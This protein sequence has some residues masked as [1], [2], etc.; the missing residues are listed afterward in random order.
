M[1]LVTAWHLPR[2]RSMLS[3]FRHVRRLD[4]ATRTAEGCEWV[5]RWGSRRSLMLTTRWRSWAEAEAWLDGPVFARATAALSRIPGAVPRLERYE[6]GT[7][8][9][10]RG[11]DV[12][13]AG[14]PASR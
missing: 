13:S 10:E 6:A 11:G 1:L 14:P 4:R 3:A 9:H 5:H 8:L 7:T 12:P 2:M